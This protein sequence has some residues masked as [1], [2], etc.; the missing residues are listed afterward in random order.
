MTAKSAVA[1]DC[2]A[3]RSN[4]ENLAKRLI[5]TYPDKIT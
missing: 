4:Y 1:Q 5:E 2:E 3:I